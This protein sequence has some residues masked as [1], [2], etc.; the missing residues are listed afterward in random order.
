MGKTRSEIMLSVD[1]PTIFEEV[2]MPDASKTIC[3]GGLTSN[4]SDDSNWYRLKSLCLAVHY[5]NRVEKSVLI[6][7][8]FIM[9]CKES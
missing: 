2:T 3:H 7:Y 6:T 9:F 4:I 5:R 1:M 8:L